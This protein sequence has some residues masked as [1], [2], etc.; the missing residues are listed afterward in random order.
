LFTACQASVTEDSLVA[1][2]NCINISNDD[3]RATCLDEMRSTIHEGN[4]DCKDQRDWRLANCQTVGQ[5]RYDPDL[6]PAHFDD[7]R[8]PSSPNPYFPLQVGNHW[9][10]L[11]GGER[12]TVD[13]VDETKL[14]QAVRGL[15]ARER[16]FVGDDLTESTDDWYAQAKD[17]T[18]WSFGEE[19]KDFESFDGD[20]P[21]RPE[22]V[23]IEGSFKTGR[24]HAKPG[25]IFLATPHVGDVYFEEFSLA[26]AEDVT[27]ILSTTYT[28]GND[29]DLDGPVPQALA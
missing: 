10:Y 22:L 11:G 15:V 6:S 28:Y 18:T 13:I 21:R 12:N 25:I 2:A 3:V 7:P 23:D 19:T 20:D 24:E 14:I 17:S 9:E 26:N 29:P 16:V 8:S 4:Q 1:K 5:D 27:E